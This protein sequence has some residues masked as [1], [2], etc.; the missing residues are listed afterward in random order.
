M[1]DSR[2]F[3]PVML[4]G[5]VLAAAAMEHALVTH[6]FSLVFVAENKAG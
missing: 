3:A 1:G 2:I 6:D 5:A 4:F